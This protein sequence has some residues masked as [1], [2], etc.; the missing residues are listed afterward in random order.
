MSKKKPGTI[1]RVTKGCM[2]AS[3]ALGAFVFG[4]LAFK[5]KGRIPLFL[6][7]GLSVS[8]VTLAAEAIYPEESNEA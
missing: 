3:C 5:S 2:S 4:V 6:A 8:S 7:G 1:N